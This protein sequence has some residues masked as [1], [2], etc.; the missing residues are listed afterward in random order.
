MKYGCARAMNVPQIQT[1]PLTIANVNVLF[2]MRC[3]HK[4]QQHQNRN[5][6]TDELEISQKYNIF[7]ARVLNDRFIYGNRIRFQLH[8]R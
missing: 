7:I 4:Q 8:T 1:A 3:R 5:V 6:K 2:Y